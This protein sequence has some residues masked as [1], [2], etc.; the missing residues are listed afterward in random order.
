MKVLARSSPLDKYLMATGLKKLN[1]VVAMS[2]DG[3]NDVSAL[4]KADIGVTFGIATE[5][6]KEASEIILLDDNFSAIT[7]TVK[8]GR[9]ILD[10]IRKFLQFQLTANFVVLMMV[11]IG[12]VIFGES[13]FSPIQMLWVHLMIDTFGSLSF[14]LETPNDKLLKKMP[15]ARN[16]KLI[17]VNMWKNIIGQGIIQVFILGGILFKGN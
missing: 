15:S 5:A 2:G 1:N 9:N 13:P 7:D 11:F 3:I 12:G 8:W 4:K 17:T 14:V 6:A 16:E 10:C